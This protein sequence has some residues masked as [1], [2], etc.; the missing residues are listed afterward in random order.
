MKRK[1]PIEEVDA[2]AVEPVSPPP[3]AQE[4]RGR[5]LRDNY[6][7]LIAS[8]NEPEVVDRSE[9][10]EIKVTATLPLQQPNML[11]MLTSSLKR[12]RVMDRWCPHEIALFEAALCVYGKQFHSVSAKVPSKSTKEV[13]EFYYIWKKGDHYRQWK[14]KIVLVPRLGL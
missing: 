5:I 4:S 2:A 13:I 6:L 9:P 10:C 1:Q 14:K 7:G 8:M 12:V 3:S 11:G